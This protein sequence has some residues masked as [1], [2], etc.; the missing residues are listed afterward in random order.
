MAPLPS[1]PD[2]SRKESTERIMPQ[3]VYEGQSVWKKY[4]NSCIIN[5]NDGGEGKESWLACHEFEPSIAEDPPC[6]EGRSTLNLSRA[7]LSSHWCSMVIWRGDTS[8]V[9][10]RVTGPWLK[11]PRSVTNSP[12]VAF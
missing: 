7:K 6:R 4:E 3:R 12:R 8:S 1:K 2:Q 9:V 10:I 11:I 5:R